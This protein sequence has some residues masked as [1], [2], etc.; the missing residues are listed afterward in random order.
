MRVPVFS[1]RTCGRCVVSHTSAQSR[2][3]PIWRHDSCGPRGDHN[4]LL[5]IVTDWLHHRGDL[6]TFSTTLALH[7]WVKMPFCKHIF[8]SQL[9]LQHW[10][11]QAFPGPRVLTPVP[12]EQEIPET[13][14]LLL[15]LPSHL[16][17]SWG[18]CHLHHGLL[19]DGNHRWRTRQVPDLP[20][21][22]FLHFIPW[23]KDGEGESGETREKMQMCYDRQLHQNQV[24]MNNSP[25]GF[26]SSLIPFSM[27]SSGILT[28]QAR[29][30]VSLG[31]G[32]IKCLTLQSWEMDFH[33]RTSKPT[34][35]NFI[36]ANNS[37]TLIHV[38]GAWIPIYSS[39]FQVLTL[40]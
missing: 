25:V 1:P 39:G 30:V 16:P 8:P 10:N 38:C 13:C 32:W 34:Y 20:T 14:H 19:S 15:Q 31:L 36:Q 17:G 18:P 27:W 29:I 28:L 24:S 35:A 22:E 33:S 12:G 21:A 7:E 5:F 2:R 26:S 3:T 23:E 37:K 11:F 9:C 4:H 40:H 6:R